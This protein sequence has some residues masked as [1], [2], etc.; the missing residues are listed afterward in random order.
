MNLE[1]NEVTLQCVTDDALEL[2]AG[3]GQAGY[4]DVLAMVV[5]TPKPLNCY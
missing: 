3:G 2:A 1:L 4:R 5:S